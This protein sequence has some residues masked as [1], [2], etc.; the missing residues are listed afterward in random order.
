MGEAKRRKQLLGEPQYKT[1]AIAKNLI[2]SLNRSPL[3]KTIIFTFLAEALTYELPPDLMPRI[4]V[5]KAT[6][7]VNKNSDIVHHAQQ[8]SGCF[9][10]TDEAT[11]KLVEILIV[12]STAVPKASSK[13]DFS[14]FDPYNPK[15]ICKALTIILQGISIGKQLNLM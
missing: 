5:E 6:N 12:I 15:D 14:Q 4:A 8:K 1:Q 10:P 7:W 2:G 13:T 9:T 3:L 11:R